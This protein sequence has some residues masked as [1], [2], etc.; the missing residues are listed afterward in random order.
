MRVYNLLH[1]EGWDGVIHDRYSGEK[2]YGLTLNNQVIFTNS[3]F[4]YLHADS[5]RIM[6]PYYKYLESDVSDSDLLLDDIGLSFQ[7]DVSL[8]E[9]QN[10]INEIKAYSH[11]EKE[12]GIQYQDGQFVY[13]MDNIISYFELYND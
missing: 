1:S 8:D 3:E 2:L 7:M 4:N 13:D 12:Y 10:R 5:S 6:I 9:I 11:E